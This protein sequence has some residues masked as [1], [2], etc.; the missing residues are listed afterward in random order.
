MWTKLSD[1]LPDNPRLLTLTRSIRWMLVE[2][3]IWSN[4]HGTDGLV[5]CAL[6][7]RI[8]DELEPAAAADLLVG[9]GFL[10]RDGSD[11]VIVGFL[12]DQPSAADTARI[13]ALTNERSRRQRQHRNGD[14]SLC[15]ARYCQQ[16]RV[17][18][19]VSNDYPPDPPDPPEGTRAVGPGKGA[20]SSGSALGRT[21]SPVEVIYPA[22]W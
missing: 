3:M 19:R 9:A 17:T 2:L 8:S 4:K 21:H 10:N 5:P 7:G 18:S 14:H 13:R 1:D 6:L 22:G 20:A 16:S 11:Y 15:D 12:D